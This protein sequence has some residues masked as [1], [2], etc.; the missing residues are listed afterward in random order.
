MIRSRAG[1]SR[2]RGSLRLLRDH[3][4]AVTPRQV[5]LTTSTSEAYSFLFRLLCDPG[6]EI[7]VPQPGYPLFDFLAVLDDV[8]ISPRHWSTTM[9]GRSIPKVSVA[10]SLRRLAP[11]FSSTPTIPPATSPSP[12]RPR[13]S[14]S[15]AANRSLPDRG[16]GL[17]GLQ[18]RQATSSAEFRCRAQGVPSSSSAASARSPACRR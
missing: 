8:R 12:G 3:G 5:I 9:A 11:S 2:A 1:C 15:S 14:P 10:P 17:P 7:L 16:R 18:L 6:S 13:S 4:V